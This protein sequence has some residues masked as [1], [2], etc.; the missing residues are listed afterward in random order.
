[1]TRATTGI[2]ALDDLIDGLRIG[3]NVLWQVAL[4]AS[5]DPF[6]SAFVAAAARTPG[7]VYVGLHV[8]P[9]VILDRYGDRWDPQRFLLVD[10]F[11]F[12]TGGGD[13]SFVRFHRSARARRARIRLAEQATDASATLD[14]LEAIQ[15][16]QPPGTRYVF[17]SLTGMEALWGREAALACFLRSCPRL[18]ELET[19]AYWLVQTEAHDP[20]SLSRLIHT[21]QVALALR[22]DGGARLKVLRAEGRRPDVVGREVAYRFE[23]GTLRVVGEHSSSRERLGRALR[24]QRIA[25][26]LSQ[27]ELARRVGISASALSQAERGRTG[28]AASTRVKLERILG[29]VLGA[30]EP[31]APPPPP[32]VISRRGGRSE[33]SVRP[34]IT[35]ELLAETDDGATF[36]LL[37]FAPHA[38]GRQPPFPT[39]RDEVIV[40]IEG[41]L[42]VRVGRAVETLQAG[43]AIVLSTEPLASWRNPSDERARVVWAIL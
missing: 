8:P 42:E 10:L 26:G 5:A 15:R 39:K 18:Y 6:V 40:V 22:A 38:S 7:L 41:V 14:L 19:V 25:R 17:D 35:A 11:T 1:M 12:G 27:A 30:T 21:T 28:L 31:S 34:G 32:Y 13:E 20:G 36:H 43:D 24:A 29:E 3:D 37:G 2:R 33:R 16:E 9:S 23:D 4:G